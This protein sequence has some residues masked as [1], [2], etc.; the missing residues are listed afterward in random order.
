MWD[1]LQALVLYLKFRLNWVFHI[2][3]CCIWQPQ[4]P[5]RIRLSQSQL[6]KP[7]SPRGREE[8]R[9]ARPPTPL[10]AVTPPLPAASRAATGKSRDEAPSSLPEPWVGAGPAE[11]GSQAPGAPGVGAPRRHR[12]LDPNS[13]LK[14]RMRWRIG[15]LIRA[16]CSDMHRACAGTEPSPLQAAALKA[17][18][19]QP[20]GP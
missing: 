6:P 4:A 3:I 13:V 19:S 1:T 15:S 2:F 18:K 14:P 5:G 20:V 10:S 12:L 17:V 16:R 8:P 11:P 7:P 9:C